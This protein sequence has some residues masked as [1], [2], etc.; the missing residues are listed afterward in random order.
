MTPA[1]IPINNPPILTMSAPESFTVELTPTTLPLVAEALSFIPHKTAVP[2][3][4][5]PAALP[6]AFCTAV[7]SPSERTP[8]HP[9]KTLSRSAPI[10]PLTTLPCS[11]ESRACGTSHHR[12]RSCSNLNHFL[13]STNIHPHI[14]NQALP[15][16]ARHYC[17]RCGKSNRLV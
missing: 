12:S 6:V 11:T 4:L 14:T 16:R 13:H 3:E 7:S 17:L 10:V 2:A 15:R 1:T 8:A 5:S 9:S